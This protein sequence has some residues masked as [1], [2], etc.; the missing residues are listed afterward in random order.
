MRHQK[1]LMMAAL[2]S[3]TLGATAA[4]GRTWTVRKDGTGIFR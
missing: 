4:A 3:L 2:I 1:T